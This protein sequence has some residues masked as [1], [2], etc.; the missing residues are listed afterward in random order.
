MSKLPIAALGLMAACAVATVS[1]PAQARVITSFFGWNYVGDSVGTPPAA[2]T[3]TSITYLGGTIPTAGLVM[4]MPAF[5]GYTGMPDGIGLAYR[6]TY[7]TRTGGDGETTR[8]IATQLPIDWVPANTLTPYGTFAFPTIGIT[9]FDTAGG[10]VYAVDPNYENTPGISL[11][12]Y[13]VGLIDPAH[14][15]GPPYILPLTPNNELISTLVWPLGD[16]YDN[17]A[18]RSGNPQLT[19]TNTGPAG[20]QVTVIFGAAIP[21]P[22]SLALLGLGLAGLGMMRRTRA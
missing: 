3:L 1:V 19:A 11:P 9:S 14:I 4:T 10:N 17:K 16:I 20:D 21:E 18:G 5:P 8:T 2:M 15:P 13:V 12:Y 6:P 22:A 7:T